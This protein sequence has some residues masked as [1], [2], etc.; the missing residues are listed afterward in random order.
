MTYYWFGGTDASYV[1]SAGAGN[2][3][4]FEPGAQVKAWASRD[5]ADQLTDM[6][7]E[8]GQPITVLTASDGTNNYPIGGL[9]R[10]QATQPT[11]WLGAD[12][13]P[14]VLAVTTDL[15]DMIAAVAAVANG[16][17]AAIDSHSADRNGHQTGLADLTDVQV[18]P[19][20]QRGV[21]QV[22]GT[23]AGGTFGLLS[24]SQ[25]AGAVLLD[26][27]DGQG[28]YVGQTVPPPDNSQ[29][30]NGPSWLKMQAAY[31]GTDDNPDMIQLGSTTQGGSW[32]KTGWFNGNGEHRAAPSTEK[33]IASRVFEYAESLGGPSTGRFVEWS[34]N[35]A[36]AANREPL[37][38][39]YGT[40][41]SSKPGW[42]EATR[43]LSALKGVSAGGNH[44]ALTPAMFRGR[45]AS[46]GAP[47]AGVWLAGDVV[48]DAAGQWWLCTVSGEP[49]TWVGG[50]G[51]GGS[52][53]AGPSAYVALTANTAGGM[54]LDSTKPGA[55]RLERG[56]DA[57]RL[58]GTLTATGAVSSGVLLATIADA[59][60]RPQ[61]T[62]QT[63]ARST[64]GGNKLTITPAGEITYSASF[65]SGQQIWLDSITYDLLP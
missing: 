45:S 8:A 53:E 24:P 19:P 1:V 9:P 52:N 48:L 62:V 17:D 41:H 20:E 29:G 32:V 27:R 43:V 59:A 50:G 58:R 23:L 63:I 47:T 7:D 18:P 46:T 35:P 16:A 25:A 49:G 42:V 12:N 37:L 40:G 51:G 30:P 14:R 21:G 6:L 44:N 56:G 33:R 39:G 28:A 4:T 65:T 54:S 15:P 61:S 55:S 26:P 3:A 5:G 13:E 38:G 64:G 10:Y 60:H 57:A 31:S 22:L 36:Q 34:T 2:A 11:I